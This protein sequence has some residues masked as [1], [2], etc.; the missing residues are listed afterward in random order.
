MKTRSFTI[1]SFCFQA[2]GQRIGTIVQSI[3]TL[4]ISVVLAIYYQWK[5]GLV[6]LCFTPFTLVATY[7]HRTVAISESFGSSKAMEKSTKVSHLLILCTFFFFFLPSSISIT[8][9]SPTLYDSSMNLQ[10]FAELLQYSKSC[11]NFAW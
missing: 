3:A 2:T 4:I 10:P 6:V 7:M 9:Y 5:L 8:L 11:L 1:S